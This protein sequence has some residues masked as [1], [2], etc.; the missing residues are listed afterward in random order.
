MMLSVLC[1]DD[2]IG[3]TPDDL[4]NVRA[5]LPRQLVGSASPEVIVE[6]GIFG[7]CKNWPVEEAASSVKEPL[8]SDIP[9]LVLEGEFDP[10][11]P[12]EYGRLVAGHLANSHFFEFRG[13]GHDVLSNECARITAGAFVNDPTQVP[14]A[15]CLAEVTGV[16]FDLPR[17]PT[18]VVLE[19][20]TD[21]ERGFSGLVPAGWSEL[22]PANLARGTSALDPAYFVLEATP[23]TAAELFANLSGQLALDAGLEP[24]KRAEVGNFTWD[25]YTFE[26]RG[27][28]LDL[29]L[30]EEGGKAYFVLLV[31]PADEHDVLYE[32]LFLP[33]IEA[34]APLP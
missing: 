8:L 15:A 19:P 18:A 11:T 22:E 14:E 10:V 20:F 27:N 28:P 23:G 21:M 9:T 2:L 32:Q 24:V 16:V 5:A 29:A 1:T 3:R 7:M 34:I 4:L 33:A 6:Y 12:P 26:L 30:A 17:G 31:S 13:V 25:F